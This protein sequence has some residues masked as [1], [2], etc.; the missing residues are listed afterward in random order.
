MYDNT[1]YGPVDYDDKDNSPIYN[2]QT[3]LYEQTCG[4]TIW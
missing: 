3:V 2:G 1:Y 4:G